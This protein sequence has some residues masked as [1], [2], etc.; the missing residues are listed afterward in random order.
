MTAVSTR[1]RNAAV[2]PRPLLVGVALG[3]V[4]VAWGSTY[5]A[6]RVMVE[7][8]PPLLGSGTRALG[9]CVLV[10]AGLAAWRGWQRLRVTRAQFAGCAAIGLLMPVAGQGLVAIAE[11]RG[12]PSGL[13]A[14]LVAAV[15]L[16]VACIRTLAGDHPSTTSTAGVTLGFGGAA[17]L[18]AGHGLHGSAPT[19]A[20]LI[21]VVASMAWAFGSW[22]Q[23]R[24]LLPADPFVVVVYEMLVGGI[25]LSILGVARGEHFVPWSYSASTWMAWAYLLLVGSVLALTAYNWLLRAT[26][27]SVDAT[28]AYVNPV[29]AVFL[30]WLILS[31]PVTTTTLLCA[32][33]VVLGVALVVASEG[34][35][36]VEAAQAWKENYA[37]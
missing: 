17:G 30:G 11:D 28:Y 18:V 29:I 1:P 22:L 8:M 6:I 3:V 32:T 37:R 23:P 24:L 19:G 25:V 31:E 12:A 20:L 4:Y 13:T 33:V 7:Q 10:A 35:D 5:L 16:W 26:S 9:A 34:R 21:V 14:L 2:G 15:P 36:R 27:V